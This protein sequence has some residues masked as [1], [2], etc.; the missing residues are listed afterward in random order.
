MSQSYPV[1]F[2]REQDAQKGRRKM[3]SNQ[4]KITALYCRLSQEDELEGESN[5]I[6]NQKAM[7][8]KYAVDNGFL[9]CRFYIDDG[10]SCVTFERPDFKRMIAD[11]DDGE[12]GTVI[13][14]DL[15][16]LGRD[17]LKT[18]TYIEI[19]FPQNDVRYIAINDGVDTDKGS[20]ELV[21]IR[22]YFNDYFAA[23]TSKKIR[24]VQR[25]KAEKG[26][27]IGSK[28]PYGYMRDENHKM[29]PDPDA[30]PVVKRIFDM[31]V[32]GIGARTIA[33]TLEKEKIHSPSAH[34]YFKFGRKEFGL[35]LDNPYQW[36]DVTI[37]N[38]LV[39][40]TYIGTTVNYKTTTKSNKLKKQN[41]NDRKDW[42]VFE[43]T[44]EAIIDKDTFAMVQKWFAGRRKPAQ[45][46]KVDIFAGLVFCA[47][48]GE[49][50]YLRRV[51]KYP[52]ENNYL[53][54]TY[55]THGGHHCS[56]HRINERDFHAVILQ[57][58][59]DVTAYVR[60]NPKEF[61]AIASSNAKV[62]A[63]KEM[64]VYRREKE[65]AEKRIAEL[66]SIIR[67]LYEDRVLGRIT[68]ERYESMSSGYETEQAELKAKLS[69]MNAA[70]DENQKREELIQSF[71]NNAKKYIDI[72]ELTPE[73]LRSFI[74]R[75]EVH[76]KEKWHSAQCGN[77]IVIHF[78]IERQDRFYV[79]HKEIVGK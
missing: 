12:I 63:E 40:E 71:I 9:N 45:S 47:D 33:M 18:G 65:K 79:W 78:T 43:N 64:K 69:E 59:R 13:T 15:S 52:K 53:C 73:I 10:Y 26:E 17:Y 29:V 66:E 7:L 44:H 54:K 61:Y 31:Y 50:M 23:D 76:E 30:A 49:R 67:C 25:A 8:S 14:K 27:R 37:R 57:K 70:I 74:S 60:E 41:H 21:G 42:L 11:M 4:T 55:Q 32:N 46:G 2:S 6:K 51:L 16:R 72:Q 20:N 28:L 1:W 35:K 58:L 68:V 39:N 19:I 62:E 24:A 48:C 34:S 38:M 5:S 36:T 56:A 77:D 3:K 75:I 22:N